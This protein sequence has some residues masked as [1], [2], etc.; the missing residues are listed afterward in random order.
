MRAEPAPAVEEHAPVVPV[1]VETLVQPYDGRWAKCRKPFKL[2]G[3][4]YSIGDD[5]PLDLI[6]RSESWVR[7]GYLQEPA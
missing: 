7:T 6:P 2:N 5:V 4:R 3:E 1:V